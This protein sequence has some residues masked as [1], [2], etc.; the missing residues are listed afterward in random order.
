MRFVSRRRSGVRRR[1]GRRPGVRDRAVPRGG[2]GSRRPHRANDGDAHSRRPRVRPR[3]PRARARRSR[4]HPSRRAGGVS[5]RR[6][7]GQRRGLA[8]RRRPSLYPYA[9]SPPRALLLHRQ[10]PDAR[11]R[12][13]DRPHRRLA[14]RRRC[15]AARPRRRGARRRRGPV[16]LAPQAR[17]ARRRGRGVSG[18]RRGIAVWE[19]DEL[20][21]VDDDRLRA[22][23]QPRARQ[24]RS[25]ALRRRGS[26][27]FHAPPAEHGAH[28]RAESRPVPRRAARSGGAP[29]TATGD[30]GARR[31]LDRDVRG[32]TL[33]GRGQRPGLGHALLD[34]GRI[35]AR[36]E[37]ARRR[38]C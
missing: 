26:R 11:G 34:E 32:G 30:A 20:E 36:L 9:G 28:R 25:R 33:R 14:V 21:G 2:Q 15:R 19:G 29:G 22:P 35:R 10:R 4:E 1:R 16:P 6:D 38:R 13:V 37:A 12:S 18:P 7:R 17:R 3:A 31:P 24:R 5:A 27:R 8:R 23:L